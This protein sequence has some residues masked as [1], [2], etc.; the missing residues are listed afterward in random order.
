MSGLRKSGAIGALIELNYRYNLNLNIREIQELSH[1]QLRKKINS[2]KE[3]HGIPITKQ[4]SR[5]D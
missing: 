5:F 1:S 3:Q 2:I 4:K